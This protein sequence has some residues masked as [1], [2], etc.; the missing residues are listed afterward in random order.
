[1]ADFFAFYIRRHLRDHDRFDGK[2]VLPSSQYLQVM[3]D[4]VPIIG[5]VAKGF[6]NKPIG[7]VDELPDFDDVNFW[8]KE[9]KK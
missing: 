1:L 5:Q 7:K 4:H 6:L 3:N 9:A 2:L 8:Q